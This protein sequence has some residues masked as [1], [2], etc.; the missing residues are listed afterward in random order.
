MDTVYHHYPYLYYLTFKSERTILQLILEKK[1]RN[2]PLK[3]KS[4]VIV[5]HSIERSRVM[6]TKQ[7]ITTFLTSKPK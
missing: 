3:M 7:V 6:I 5:S 4:L 1:F 2:V